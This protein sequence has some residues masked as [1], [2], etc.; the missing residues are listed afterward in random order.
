VITLPEGVRIALPPQDVVARELW[1]RSFEEPER[2]LVRR[3]LRPGDVVYDIGAHAGLYSAIAATFVSP[4][5]R[6]YAFEPNPG[7]FA[8]LERNVARNR[9]ASV[10]ELSA[11]AL[12]AEAGTLMLH[13][14]DTAHS[15]WASFGAPITGTQRSIRVHVTTLDALT[16][17]TRPPFLVKL[18]VE[19]WETH[20]LAGGTAV[21]AP[22]A[23]PHLLVEFTDR[24]ATAAGSSTRALYDALVALGYGLYRYRSGA[25]EPEPFRGAYPYDNLVATKRPDEL[26]ER[27]GGRSQS[28]GGAT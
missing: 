3:V 17:H 20:V 19:G 11:A 26:A 7:M 27:L 5:G 15:A 16:G 21:L 2:E 13:V 22:P 28:G 8:L 14:P 24:I 18:D 25:L 4:G 1:T 9:L 6:V 10:V 12:G 23:A